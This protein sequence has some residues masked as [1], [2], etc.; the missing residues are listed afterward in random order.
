MAG[1]AQMRGATEIQ[2]QLNAV[3]QERL[4]QLMQA[5]DSGETVDVELGC[6]EGEF[7]AKVADRTKRWMIGIDKEPIHIL[8]A[9]QGFSFEEYKISE[10]FLYM[11]H[12]YYLMLQDWGPLFSWLGGKAQS[13]YMIM[14]D[15][16]RDHREEVALWLKLAAPQ[17][18]LFIKSEKQRILDKVESLIGHPYELAPFPDEFDD[19]TTYTTRFFSTHEGDRILSTGFRL[20]GN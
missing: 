16:T 20:L 5:L 6:G 1:L 18:Q 11:P 13:T 19:I 9:K 3:N 12:S 14:P 15:P 10:R 17:G 2:Q 4:P 8:Y 7:A